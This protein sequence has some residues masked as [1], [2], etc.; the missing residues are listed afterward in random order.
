MRIHVSGQHIEVTRPLRDYVHGKLD[1]IIRHFDHVHD[2]HVV[3]SV[4]K[5]VHQA[6]VTINCAPHKRMHAQAQDADMYAAIDLLAD[7]LD[8]QVRKHKEKLTNHH[9][10]DAQRVRQAV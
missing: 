8:A 5:L 7:K 1:R 9:R 3:L 2:A 10:A 6:E 4:E